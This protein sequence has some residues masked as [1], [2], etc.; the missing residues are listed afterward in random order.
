MQ[1]PSCGTRANRPYM[2]PE[3]H[4][5]QLKLI[6]CAYKHAAE[7]VLRTGSKQGGGGRARWRARRPGLLRVEDVEL[8]VY[9]LPVN[10]GNLPPKRFGSAVVTVREKVVW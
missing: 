5:N 3:R 8:S 9:V 1:E 7:P 2:T 6:K 4:T 10:S